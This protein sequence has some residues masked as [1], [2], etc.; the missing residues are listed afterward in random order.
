MSLLLLV[1][2]GSKI[3]ENAIQLEWEAGDEFHVAAS[4]RVANVK[5]DEIPTDLEGGVAEFGEH[6]TDDVVWTYQVVET[7]LVPD[8]GDELYEYALDGNGEPVAIS[9][10]RAWLDASLND[11]SELL[12]AD[13]VV[14]LVF[15]EQRDRLAAVVSFM[16]TDSSRAEMAWTSTENGRSWSPLSQSM[17]TA[18]PTYLAPWS[19]AYEDGTRTLENGSE[20]TTELD[21]DETVDVYYEDE[22]GGGMVVSRYEKGSPWPTWTVSDNV[23][24]RLLSGEEVDAKRARVRPMAGSAPEDFD[25]KAA[26]SASID[27]ESALTLDAE[28]MGGGWS[29]S[30]YDEYIPWSG[31]WWKQSEAALVFGYD[32]RDTISDR[33]KTD[34]DPIK[35]DMDKLSEE[36]RNLSDGSEKDAKVTEYQTKQKELVEK[37]VAFYDGVLQDLDGGRLTVANGKITHVDGWSYTLD[38]LSPMDKVALAMYYRGETSPNPFYGPAWELLNHYSPAGGS[39]WGH[40]NGWSAAA[41]LTD[42]PTSSVSYD[43]NGNAVTYTTADI[44][45]LLSETHYSTYSRFYGERYNGKD[46]NL[47]DLTPAAFHKLVSFYVRE[48]GVPLVFDTTASEEVWNFPAYD[49][50]MTVTETTEGGGSAKVNVNTATPEQLDELPGIGETLAARIVEYRELNGPFQAKEDVKNVDGIGEGIYADIESLIA[51]SASE[52]TFKVS[53]HVTLATDGVAETYIGGGAGQ[54]TTD[55]TWGYSLVT[56]ENGLV[57]RGTWDDDN[58]HPDFAWIPYENPTSVSSGNSENPYLP[59]GTVLDVIGTSFV[60]E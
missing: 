60:R 48:Q 26:L 37:L 2:C 49:V 40:C 36:I 44:K 7:G 12:A 51:V 46:Q 42:E 31:S 54:Q 1:A 9:V 18:A 20:V 4:Y 23:D 16:D 14:Y 6:W 43:M 56:D 38:E 30:V 41:I 29:D 59:Y 34:I 28:T 52:R 35:T 10:V 22:L 8:E 39:W 21:G 24:I 3:P 33:I 45:G 53:A 58:T 27:I 47:G 55:Y 17:L 13:P 11:D 57:L 5:T 15:H 19:A 32:G 50:G 25:Y